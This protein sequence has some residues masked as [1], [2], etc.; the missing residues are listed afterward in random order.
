MRQALKAG[1][2]DEIYIDLVPLL[3]GKGIPLFE[4]LGIEPVELEQLEV[5][6]GQGVTHLSY[7][8]VK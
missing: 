5:I 2:L 8:V 7:R 1:I 4:H 6:E 3:L